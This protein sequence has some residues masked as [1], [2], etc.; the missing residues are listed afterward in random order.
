MRRIHPRTAA[1]TFLV[2][3]YC[4]GL[5]ISIFSKKNLFENMV[6]IGIGVTIG[7]IIHKI[8]EKDYYDDK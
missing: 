6:F 5:L 2:I 4:I 3:Y 8:F 7:V 1:A